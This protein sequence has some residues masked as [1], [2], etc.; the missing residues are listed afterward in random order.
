LS[1]FDPEI[2]DCCTGWRTEPADKQK[3]AS[4]ANQISDFR[5]TG[6]SDGPQ[7]ENRRPIFA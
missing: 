6:G 2:P 7:Q 5:Q 4:Q 1:E 3:S